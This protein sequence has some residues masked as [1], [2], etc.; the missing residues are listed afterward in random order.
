ML[1]LLMLAGCDAIRHQDG[2]NFEAAGI[3]PAQFDVLAPAGNMANVLRGRVE[4]LTCGFSVHENYFAWQAFG[5]AY[6]KNAGE[7]LPP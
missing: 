6:A 2:D 5:R 3:P 7:P 1:S 4:R